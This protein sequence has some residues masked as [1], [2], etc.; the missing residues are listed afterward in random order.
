MVASITQYEKGQRDACLETLRK[1]VEQLRI[2]LRL[3]HET[4]SEDKIARSVWMPY[5]QGFQGWAAGEIE[6]GVYVEYDG[7]SGNQLPM[8]FFVDA[9]LGLSQYLPQENMLRYVPISQRRLRDSLSAHNFREKA[10]LNGDVAIEAEMHKIVKQ[11]RVFFLPNSS[12]SL[13]SLIML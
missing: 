4:L 9:F 11:M 12:L 6:D 10:K 1:I 8:S 3:Y 2:P 7:L 5:V 13:W